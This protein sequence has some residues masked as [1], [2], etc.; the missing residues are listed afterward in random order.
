[1]SGFVVQVG[2]D[3]SGAQQAMTALSQR[4]QLLQDRIAKLQAVAAN[5]TSFDKLTKATEL[6][7]RSQAELG[8]LKTPQSFTSLAQSSNQATQSLSNLSRVAQD[9]PYGF[10]GIANNINPLLESFQRLKAS[11]GT[12]SSA[13]KAMGAALTGPAGIGLAVGVISSLLVSFGDRLFQTSASFSEAEFS[14]A[15][16]GAEIRAIKDD[17]DAL[18]RSLD[19]KGALTKI[20]LELSGL[21]GAGLTAAGRTTD[22][23]NNAVAIADLTKKIDSLS[24]ANKKLI[25]DR[26]ALENIFLSQT[27]KAS[28]L[29]KAVVGL[30]GNLDALSDDIVKKLSKADQALVARYKQTNEQVKDLQKQRFDLLGKNL[31]DIA[32]IPL[33]FIREGRAEID[34][35]KI[36]PKKI[37]IDP[38][39]SDYNIIQP[40]RKDFSVNT[41]GIKLADS[42]FLKEFRDRNEAQVSIIREQL[43]KL[44]DIGEFVGNSIANAFTNAFDAIGKGENPIR[45]L[46]N[47]V[48]SLV[49]DL[50]QAAIRALI[51]KAIINLFAPGAGAAANLGGL[52]GLFE[53]LPGRA[54]GGSVSGGRAYM[55]GERGPE[56]FMAQSSGRIVPNHQLNGITGAGFQTIRVTGT[57]RGSGRD[58]V[59]VISQENSYQ[60]RN[61]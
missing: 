51:V 46:G 11:T 34:K 23:Q 47:A 40:D 56:L 41:A 24:G 26:A 27:G 55:V 35:I 6:V 38:Q 58:L 7:K 44:R 15:K 49:M 60:R 61:V 43:L 37:E 53:G 19:L 30:G 8:R 48:K 31:I 54:S 20:G 42:S 45:A 18:R 36:K 13:F 17:V 2:G 52:S 39:L 29:G 3:T 25:A 14:A 9:A 10:I 32:S 4:M 50:I 59:A 57:L 22:I 16:F 1:M 5:T 33:D 12:T 28:S 21:K